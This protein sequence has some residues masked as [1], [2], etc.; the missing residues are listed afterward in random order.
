LVILA[1][2]LS[3]VTA[4]AQDFKESPML[5]DQVAAGTLPAAA[6]RLPANP[7]VVTPLS[8]TGQYGGTLRVG[9]VGTS[10][11]W[12]GL[13]YIA[14]WDQLT[15]WKPDFSGVVPNIAESWDVSDDATTYTFH[16]RKGMKWSDGEPF[17]ADDIMFYIN[18]IMLNPD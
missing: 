8:E 3:A 13:L 7:A 17:S 6:E 2:A 12:G 5:A 9:F 18:D 4:L 14:G 11:G 16:L 1:F 10:P 15:Q